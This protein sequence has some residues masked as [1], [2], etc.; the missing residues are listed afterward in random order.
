MYSI[1]KLWKPE[2]DET[3]W[4]LDIDFDNKD[5]DGNSTDGR[6]CH[7]AIIVIHGDSP[8]HCML[9]ANFICKFLNAEGM[10][11]AEVL[12]HLM[13]MAKVNESLL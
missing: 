5:E 8:S 6:M 9:K 11:V 12:V 13:E 3:I 1:G 4:T 2:K 10:K 7:G